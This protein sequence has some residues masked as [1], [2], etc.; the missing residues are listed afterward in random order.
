[1]KAEIKEFA[2][3]GSVCQERADNMVYPLSQHR[4][5]ITSIAW[6]L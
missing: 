5:F 3:K 4:T 2:I 1:M 6:L